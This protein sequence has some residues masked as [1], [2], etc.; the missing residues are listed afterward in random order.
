LGWVPVAHVCNPNYSG[1]IDQEDSISKPAQ[2]DSSRDPISK[3]T[4]HKNGL[5]EW[6]KSSSP[7]T[8]KKKSGNWLGVVVHT[9]NSSTQEVEEEGSRV[10]GQHRLHSK[11][12]ADQSYITRPC[13]KN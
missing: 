11:F 8:T 1:G 3:K 9:Y 5:A 2:A 7:C 13:L 12:E 6:F 4:H 10:R